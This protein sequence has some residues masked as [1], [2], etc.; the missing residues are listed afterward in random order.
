MGVIYDKDIRFLRIVDQMEDMKLNVFPKAMIESELKQINQM[1]FKIKMC[2]AEEISRQTVISSNVLTLVVVDVAIS[3]MKLNFDMWHF[4]D[5][6]L[7][8]SL[9]HEKWSE[10]KSKKIN[11]K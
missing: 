8:K 9:I 6:E 2:M 7:L 1:A 3:I 4:D 11:Y 5:E 10:I